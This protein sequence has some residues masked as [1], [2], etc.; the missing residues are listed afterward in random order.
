MLKYVLVSTTMFVM[1]L[2]WLSPDT[3]GGPSPWQRIVEEFEM[4]GL[5]ETKLRLEFEKLKVQVNATFTSENKTVE[6]IF[7]YVKSM[8]QKVPV[9]PHYFK[10]TIN[11][12][13]ICARRDIFLLAYIHSAPE[14]YKRRTAIRDTWGNQKN[15]DDL[16]VRVVFLMGKP[17]DSTTAEALQLESDTYSDIV[18]EDFID[19]YRNLTYKAIM[20]LKWISNNCK[21]ARF[22]LKTDDDIFVNIFNLV[23]HLRSISAHKATVKRLLLCLVW[24]RMKVIRDPKSK[25]YLSKS[26]FSEDYFPT[27]CSGSAY[28]MSTDVVVDMYNTSLQTP[29]FWVD[30]FYITGL[31]ARKIGI[32]HHKFNSVYVLG[33]SV[34][35]EKF[36]E[37]N[38]WQTLV[39]GHVHNLN[40]MQHVWNRILEERKSSK[41]S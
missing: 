9:N 19:S 21:H 36:T 13:Q 6:E 16:T 14:H 40:Q 18:Q 38:K 20:G 11:P 15:F 24:Y 7:R 39:F 8:K 12:T 1:L 17:K 27:Y 30:D 25:W 4:I 41:K 28:V 31:L 35:Y 23:S 10:Y 26:E 34:F 22:I 5:N 33:P 3:G 37:A 29:F 32:E 2:L